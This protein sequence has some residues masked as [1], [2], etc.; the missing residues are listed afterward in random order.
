MGLRDF[1]P[2]RD[3]DPREFGERQADNRRRVVGVDVVEE[4]RA[5]GFELIGARA[6][7]RA[8][9]LDLGAERVVSE[10]PHGHARG[11]NMLV[12]LVLRRDDERSQH[13]VGAS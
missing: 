8:V 9:A 11:C 4:C 7:K 3:E 2:E 1:K 12:G 13:L 6:V 10:R 5:C